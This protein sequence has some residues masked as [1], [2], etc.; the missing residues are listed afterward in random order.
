MKDITVGILKL[1]IGGCVSCLCFIFLESPSGLP[2]HRCCRGWKNP[3]LLLNT[4]QT[5]TPADSN[6]SFLLCS[7]TGHFPRPR[8][9]VPTPNFNESKAHIPPER[10]SNF[11][12]TAISNIFFPYCN[13]LS[14]SPPPMM[15][16]TFSSKKIQDQTE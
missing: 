6:T 1:G 10:W 12:T 15:Q 5:E 13:K 4:I 3:R 9:H 2:G 7:V 14:P 8:L 16:T 11:G